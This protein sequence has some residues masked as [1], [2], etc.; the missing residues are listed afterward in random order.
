MNSPGGRRE[1]P[2]NQDFFVGCG[3]VILQPEEIVVSVFIPFSRKVHKLYS[4]FVR[5]CC[6]SSTLVTHILLCGCER[7]S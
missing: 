2:L 4:L 7:L 3:K 1:V 6:V 5:T